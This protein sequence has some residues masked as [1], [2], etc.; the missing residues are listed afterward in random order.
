MVLGKPLRSRRRVGFTLIELLV[1]IAIIGILIGML[2]PAVQNVRQ[3]AAR[4]YHQNQVKQVVLSAVSFE[5]AK[6]RMPPMWSW[7][8]TTIPATWGWGNQNQPFGGK[9]GSFHYYLLQHIEGDSIVSQV[10]KYAN[11]GFPA[12]QYG[13][14]MPAT[15]NPTQYDLVLRQFIAR[16]DPGSA[17]GTVQAWGATH[18]TTNFAFNFMIPAQ[19]A[20]N[21]YGSGSAANW[22]SAI[23]QC[24]NFR[25]T[26]EDVI[27][28]SSN[29]IL[30]AE[31]YSQAAIRNGAPSGTIG[32]SCWAG[33][34]GGD[35]SPTA[36]FPWGWQL[37][38]IFNYADYM[39]DPGNPAGPFL[40]PPDTTTPKPIDANWNTGQ[41]LTGG[42]CVVG[43]LD[44][45]V[46][47]FSGGG[48]PT[49]AW[50]LLSLPADKI[51]TP[52][53]W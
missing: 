22:P 9:S 45:S 24:W 4:A 38:P 14:Y 46:R 7:H 33:W 18:G 44:G 19:L 20:N 29:T 23:W 43:M 41:G 48:N 26:T 28:G 49:L 39:P 27:D 47:N 50:T 11:P 34:Y 12:N 21:Q 37:Q 51:P 5:T 16:R 15:G 36:Y 2:L 1:V 6:N 52:A 42:V 3:A 10:N 31:K 8:N 35:F 13:L 53:D 40:P 30:I 17:D 25:F 32:Y